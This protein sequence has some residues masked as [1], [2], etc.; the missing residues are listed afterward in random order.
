MNNAE[1]PAYPYTI[2]K[3][4]KSEHYEYGLTKREYFAAMAM[5][6]IVANPQITL[7]T[8][9]AMIEK[10]IPFTDNA[11]IQINATIK[12]SLDIADELLKQLENN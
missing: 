5:Q 9:N 8:K 12:Y 2:H 6:G 10:G 1:K 3:G 7:N 11:E 4:T